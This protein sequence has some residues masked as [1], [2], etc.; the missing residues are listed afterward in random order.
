MK[1]WS[2]AAIGMALPALIGLGL[3]VVLPFLLAIGLSFTNARLGSP[4]G[5][6]FVG[7]REY[8]YVLSDATFW[9]ALG[10]NCLFAALIV[11]GQ[12]ALAL[13]LALLL[14][15]PLRGMVVFRTLFFMPVIFPIALVS[16][17]WILIFAPGPEGMLNGFL[18]WLS[19]G[20]WQP[21]DFLNDPT[22]ALPAVVLTSIWQ[23]A[24]FQM[25]VLLAGLQSIDPALHE[26]AA[27]DGAGRFR[28]FLHVTL[29]GLRN[30]LIF[31]TIVTTI[32][33]FRIFDQ[34][35]IMTN[36]G[37]KGATTTVVYEIVQA[38]FDRAQLSRGAAMAVLFFVLVLGLTL[39][40]RRVFK[41][42]GAVNR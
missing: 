4:L 31:V 35:R 23:G 39:I 34:V 38:A 33:S 21:R 11:P 28:R 37:P 2:T 6:Q 29:P 22:W 7:L 15:Q 1:K 16:V 14:N 25:V 9:R 8:V 5:I 12:T 19:G 13:G 41:Q 32:L 24:G 40:Q 17:V 10:N 3:F 36:G 42:H 20:A 30:P 27:M 26:A 18:G